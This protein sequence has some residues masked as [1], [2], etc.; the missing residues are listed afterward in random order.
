MRIPNSFGEGSSPA[1]YK[2]TLVVIWDHEGDSFITA[3][4]KKTGAPRWRKE[5]RER[6]SWSTPLVVEVGGKPQVLVSATGASC[7]YDLKTGEVLWT[8]SGMTSNAIPSPAYADGMAY[9]MSGFRGY[10]L[11]AIK[12]AGAKGNL[13]GTDALVW[14]HGEQ[15]SYVPSHLVYQGNVYFLRDSSGVLS[16][17]DAKTGEVRYQ[18]KRMSRIGTTYSSPVGAGGKVYITSRRG[19]TKVLEAGPKYKEIA[20]NRLKDMIDGTPAIVGDEIYFRGEKHLYCIA[21]TPAKAD[22]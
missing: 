3:L 19:Y 18:G 16:C 14:E 10:K 1:L 7:A 5:R 15:T 12:L 21:T 4:D 2:D 8:C 13:R 9:L 22:K 6:T 20:T 17:L 11:Q